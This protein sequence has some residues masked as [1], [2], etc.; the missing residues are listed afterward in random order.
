MLAPLFV[1]GVGAILSGYFF[2][3]LFIGNFNDVFWKDSIFFLKELNH[4]H[5]PTW[6]LVLTPILVTIAIPISYYYFVY[7][8]KILDNFKKTNMP[9][10]NFLL[11]KWYIDEIYDYLFC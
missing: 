7:D 5:V 4:D 10:Y 11:N 9:L 1:L 3:E 6:F 8:Q 2:K